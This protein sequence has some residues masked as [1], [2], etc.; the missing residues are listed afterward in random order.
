M[1]KE[2]R[3]LAAIMLTDIVGYTALTQTDEALTLALLDEH[4]ALLRPLFATHDGREVKGTGDGFLVEFPSAL[5]AVRCAVEIQRA[6]H[7]RNSVVPLERAIQVRIGIHLG[8]IVHRGSDIFGDGVNITARI[9]PLAEPGGICLS[10][11]VYD[12]VWNK[13]DHRMASLGKR[14]LKNLKVPIEVYEVELP[15]TRDEATSRRR[16]DPSRLLV[17]PLVSMSPDPQDAYFADG[18]TEELIFCLSKVRELQVIALTSAMKYRGAQKSISE[19]GSELEVGAV[20]EGSVR[21]AGNRLRIT[22]QLIDVA[23]EAHLWSE[24]YERALGDVFSIQTEIA[25]SVATMLEV[26]LVRGAAPHAEPPQADPE[27]Y[28]MYLKGRVLF[29]RRTADNLRGAVRC[30]ERAIELEPSRAEFH[31][32]LSMAYLVFSNYAEPPCADWHARAT[33]GAAKALGLDPGLAQAH[34]ARGLALLY[35]YDWHGAEQEYRRAIALSPSYATAHH[36]L[37]LLLV[38]LGRLDEAAAALK[39]ALKLDPLSGAQHGALAQVYVF[40]GK[41]ELALDEF[42]V[43]SALGEDNRVQWMHRGLAYLLLGRLDHA[44]GDLRKARELSELFDPE[45]EFWIAYVQERAGTHGALEGA[46]QMALEH[47]E[48][49]G[50]SSYTLAA[51]YC[52][53]GRADQTFELLER[54]YTAREPELAEV[55]ADPRFESCRSDPRFAHFLRRIGVAK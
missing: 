31:A 1:E 24:V 28:E 23:G 42:E 27:A 3:H 36:W 18:L 5:E 11:Q 15:W 22:V 25:Q 30:F 29:S 10:R 48:A 13:V 33:A 4:A 6:L 7:E 12:A 44:L 51:Y 41:A 54:A 26:R 45:V 34:A 39:T 38:T 8:D 40:A 2:N 21:K 16:A 14:E 46:L 50:V 47:R 32:A 53:L 55:A 35:D 9:E 37:G 43:A 52:A 19:I 17:L 20:I 49:R